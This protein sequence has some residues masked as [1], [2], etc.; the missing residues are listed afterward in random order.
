MIVKLNKGQ[1]NNF[2]LNL[3]YPKGHEK[4]N[5]TLH[6]ACI[7]GTGG[8]GKTTLLKHISSYCHANSKKY[9]YFPSGFLVK[10]ESNADNA[11]NDAKAFGIH[12]KNKKGFDFHTERQ[13][14]LWD[15]ILFEFQQYAKTL[16]KLYADLGILQFSKGVENKSK[17][18]RIETQIKALTENS[19]LIKIKN[20][21][22]PLL[23][24]YFI[25]V[26]QNPL[27]LDF[28]MLE[29]LKGEY[30]GIDKWSTGIKRIVGLVL[31]LCL[32]DTQNTFILID[33]IGNFLDA[34]TQTLLINTCIKLA[35]N[36]HFI[37]TTNNH[38]IGLQ[39]KDYEK[40]T[41]AYYD[42]IFITGDEYGY[43]SQET[44]R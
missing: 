18:E 22:N 29:T 2:E 42:K 21:L 32:L 14:I 7:I 30:L 44:N 28:I 19:P 8:T 9:I 25:R 33:D 43:I 24:K 38:D 39:F 10:Y 11:I 34:E 31:P 15:M 12:A 17:V 35:P 5:T 4:E 40:I 20:A 37:F 1:F 27:H 16:R 36:A 41:I 13:A 3:T 6:K 26:V 23:E